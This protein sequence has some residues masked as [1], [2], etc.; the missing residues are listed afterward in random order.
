MG[1]SSE[2]PACDALDPVVVKEEASQVGQVRQGVRSK[3]L[4]RV[5]AQVQEGEPDKGLVHGGVVG[6]GDGVVGEVELGGEEGHRGGRE[7]ETKSTAV[8]HAS[9]AG[10][11]LRAGRVHG[12]G[13]GS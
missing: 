11:S 9:L 6:Q 8:H 10:A 3:L 13:E 2:G 12:T 4:D 5:V 1:E 7:D